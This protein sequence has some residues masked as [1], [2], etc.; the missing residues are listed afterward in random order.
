MCHV[1]LQLLASFFGKPRALVGWFCAL[2]LA[3]QCKSAS[4]LFLPSPLLEIPTTISKEIGRLV[5]G[6]HPCPV[7]PVWRGWGPLLTS[8]QGDS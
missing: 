5:R 6:P 4:H 7:L 2:D 1:P 8:L 3:P